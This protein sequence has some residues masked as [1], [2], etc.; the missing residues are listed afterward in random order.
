[1]PALPWCII[2]RMLDIQSEHDSL[3]Q[4]L[5]Q[6]IDLKYQAG[7]Q[8][9]VKTSLTVYGVRTPNLR[10]I[11]RRWIGAHRQTPWPEVLGFIETLWCAP[12]QEERVSAILLLEGLPWRIPELQW[13]HFDRWRR[14]SN[15]WGLT[16]GLG[17]I[18][19]GPWIKADRLAR[20]KYLTFL[21]R[22]S[23][24]WS[25]RLALVTTIPL[26]RQ[27]S[28]AIPNLTL[29]LID[30]VKEE[31]DPMITKAVSW[32]LRELTKTHKPRVVDYLEKNRGRLAPLA[33]R[34]TEN[35]LRTGLKSGKIKGVKS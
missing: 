19:L 5:R 9:V 34:E 35:K 32:A 17:G 10:R 7:M 13:D 21:I 20:L 3:L 12:S 25:R 26:N 2:P 16:D 4:A 29:Q 15:N 6:N 22:E 14:M 31:R 8:M 28:S 27:E 11:A 23:D 1:M 24:R 30:Q 18:A 33:V